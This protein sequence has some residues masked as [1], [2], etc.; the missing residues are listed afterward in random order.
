MASAE[1]SPQL[2]AATAVRLCGLWV[3]HPARALSYVDVW[4]RLLLSGGSSAAPQHAV[5]PLT[6]SQGP[7]HALTGLP[8]M[9]LWIPDVLMPREDD[10]VEH[11]W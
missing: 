11:I 10:K 1:R 2:L 7:F 9:L 8:V 4:E 3:Q 5:R 6:V